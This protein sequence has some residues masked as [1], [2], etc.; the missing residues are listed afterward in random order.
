[1]KLPETSEECKLA[2]SGFRSISYKEAISN[3]VGVLDGYLFKIN[4]PRKREAENVRSY[5]SGHYQCNGVNIQAVADHHCRFSYLAVAA[6]GSTGDND[7]IYQISL[8]SRI[9]ALPL[10]YCIIADAAYTANEHIVSIYSGNDRLI[11]K[12]D[13]F[14]FY[15]S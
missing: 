2:A 1:M 5:Y 15:A 4:T 13:D 7:A 10:G 14:N 9:A 6:P 8:A 12:N 11:Q 3:C